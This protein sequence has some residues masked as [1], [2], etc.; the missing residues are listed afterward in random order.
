MNSYPK[1]P[2]AWLPKTAE[3]CASGMSAPKLVKKY[4]VR[5]TRTIYL[6]LEKYRGE[7]AS[8]CEW[9]RESA[10]RRL[11]ASAHESSSAPRY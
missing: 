9:R 5:S 1:I 6:I 7:Q 11:Q 3:E 8:T 10:V 4:G 2:R